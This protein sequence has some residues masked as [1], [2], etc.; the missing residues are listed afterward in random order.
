MQVIISLY[1]EL[2][3]SKFGYVIVCYGGTYKTDLGLLIKFQKHYI[4]S[5]ARSSELISK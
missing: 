5:G 2:F 1:F 3:H 4:E